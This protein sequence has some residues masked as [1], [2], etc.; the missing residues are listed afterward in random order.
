MQGLFVPFAR[1]GS[2][3]P[4][5]DLRLFH[6]NTLHAV[7]AFIANDNVQLVATKANVLLHCRLPTAVQLQAPC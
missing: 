6:N 3:D 4:V 2:G 7:E 5:R 1:V